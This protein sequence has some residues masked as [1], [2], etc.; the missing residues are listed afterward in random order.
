[1][2]ES[3]DEYEVVIRRVEHKLFLGSEVGVKRQ[4]KVVEHK[5]V[6]KDNGDEK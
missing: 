6:F 5:Y 2:K 4:S 1:M 3:I